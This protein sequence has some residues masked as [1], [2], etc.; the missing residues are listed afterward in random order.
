MTLKDILTDER[1][2]GADSN[3]ISTSSLQTLS[4]DLMRAEFTSHGVPLLGDQRPDQYYT[5]R[6]TETSRS[7]PR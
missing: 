5:K 1:P 7:C 3:K 4:E 6:V 2:S